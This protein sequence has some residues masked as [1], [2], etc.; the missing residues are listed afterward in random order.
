MDKEK[1]INQIMKEFKADGDSVTREEAEEIAEMEIRAKGLKR[2]EKGEKRKNSERVRKVDDFKG[3]ILTALRPTI[4]EF[5]KV[6]F[7]LTETEL[8]F[9][10]D[11]VQYTLK[12]TRHGKK[13]TR[14]T[15]K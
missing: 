4:E 5:G 10:V 8:D 14:P 2:Y 9:V 12:L 15:K 6:T 11:E 3:E 7:Q 13:W 1:L